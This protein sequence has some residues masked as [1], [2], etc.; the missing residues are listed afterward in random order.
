MQDLFTDADRQKINAAMAS[1]SGSR[2]TE[3]SAATPN[4][5]GTMTWVTRLIGIVVGIVVGLIF[6]AVLGLAGLIGLVVLVVV[7]I[8][9]ASRVAGWLHRRKLQAQ[10]ER[11]IVGGWAAQRGWTFVERI[12]VMQTTPLLRQ[13]DR[14]ETGWGVTGQLEGGVAF[15]AGQYEYEVDRQVSST[16]SD[17]NTTT[18]TETDYHPFT[19]ALLA[20]PLPDLNQIAIQAGKTGGILSK[21][22]GLV[23]SLRPVELESAEFNGAFRLMVA[24]DADELAIRMRFTPAVQVALIERGPGA[25]QIEGENDVLLVARE[26]KTDTDDFGE[27]LDVLGDAIWFRALLTDVPAGRVPDTATLRRLLLGADA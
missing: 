15:A 14:R 2:F 8:F 19:V 18:R 13:G 16:D 22:S 9:V 27:L 17:G 12:P 1:G 3:L 10:A 11:E 6:V 20:A 4:P 25:S 24:D 23:T 7:A 5:S 21:L 26:G